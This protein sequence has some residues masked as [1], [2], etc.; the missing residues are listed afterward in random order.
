MKLLLCLAAL[1]V[2]AAPVFA[3]E[4][5]SPEEAYKRMQERAEARK[6]AAA[7]QPAQAA[8]QP[9]ARVVAPK[10]SATKPAADPNAPKENPIPLAG[11]KFEFVPPPSGTWDLADQTTD[12]AASFSTKDHEAT[13]VIQVLPVN[14]SVD[15]N[16]ADALAHS[17]KE[18]HQKKKIKMMLEP[19][20]EP[21]Q[22]FML[23][24]HERYEVPSK[25]GEGPSGK[26]AD[27][28]HL[29]RNVGNTTLMATFYIIS[30][31]ADAVK[32]AQ[33]IAEDALLSA[34]ASG[35]KGPARKVSG[36]AKQ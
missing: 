31:D 24:I 10:R 22:R 14:M 8:S 12:K 33:T 23:K 11:G 27:S 32:A 4:P 3:D 2:C 17:L 20:V 13:L 9:A 16:M 6:K 36:A 25:P 30:E 1:V 34:T 18:S 21:D 35:G 29:Y 7:S 28:L 26:T 19:T 5:V 15:S